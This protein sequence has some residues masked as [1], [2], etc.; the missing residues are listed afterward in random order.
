M[1]QSDSGQIGE[2]LKSGKFASMVKET[3]R[4]QSITNSREAYHIMKSLFIEHDRCGGHLLHIHGC[5]K[6]NFIHRK[7]SN[8][9]H[10]Y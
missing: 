9:M 2:G 1:R 4:G 10:T 7:I 3:S 6:Q 5:Q 8:C